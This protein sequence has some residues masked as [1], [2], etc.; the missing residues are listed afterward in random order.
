MIM[1]LC[2]VGLIMQGNEYNY[3]YTV[4]SKL[5]LQSHPLNDIDNLLLWKEIFFGIIF[6][7]SSHDK[8]NI[9]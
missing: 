7:I 6:L 4:H 1:M 3:Y 9:I 8:F 5:I 2:N